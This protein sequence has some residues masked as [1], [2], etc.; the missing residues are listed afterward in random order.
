MA[1]MNHGRLLQHLS[2][3]AAIAQ[4]ADQIWTCHI[5]SDELPKYSAQYQVL[6]SAYNRDNSL[7]IRVRNEGPPAPEFSRT[8]PNL[9]DVYFAALVDLPREEDGRGI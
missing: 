2:P 1:I 6:S 9:E 3:E 4:L 8:A 5:S 7:R